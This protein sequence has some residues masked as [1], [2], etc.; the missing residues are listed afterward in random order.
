MRKI[1]DYIKFKNLVI[2]L[3]IFILFYFSSLFRLIPISL[4]KID[5][6]NANNKVLLTLFSDLCL[7]LILI[8]IYRKELI[9]EFKIFKNNAIKVI[10]IST[11]CWIIGLFFMFATNILINIVFKAGGANNEKLVQQMI[12]SSPIIMLITA[13][14]IAPMIEELI[15][16]KSFRNAFPN[17]Y[18]FIIISS[19]V[20]GLLHVISSSNLVGLLY[21]I[22]YTSLGLAFAIAYYKT[23][24]IFSSLFIHILHNFI[25]ILLAII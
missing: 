22:P 14:I 20:F 2:L 12:S 7:L 17:K 13:G 9:K 19:L 3:L 15:F 5:P 10:D 8:L 16:R 21:I 25:L 11:K 4:F 23:D 6:N 18:L 1:K 24:T